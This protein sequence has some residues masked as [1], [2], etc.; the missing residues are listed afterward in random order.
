MWL[1]IFAVWRSLNKYGTLRFSHSSIIHAEE[2]VVGD[3]APGR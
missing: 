3:P 1:R 2:D